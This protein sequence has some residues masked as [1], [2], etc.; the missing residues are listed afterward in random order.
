MSLNTQEG[1]VF[2]YPAPHRGAKTFFFLLLLLGSGVKALPYRNVVFLAIIMEPLGSDLFLTYLSL[3]FTVLF[4]PTLSS[5]K[6]KKKSPWQ[7][8]QG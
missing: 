6:K 2:E 7:V 8:S 4:L 1:N 5:I 3:L